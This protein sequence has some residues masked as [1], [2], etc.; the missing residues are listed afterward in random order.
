[1][2]N[3]IATHA[4]R[5]GVSLFGWVCEWVGCDASQPLYHQIYL[6]MGPAIYV[7]EYNDP[8]GALGLGRS[9]HAQR[10][11]AFYIISLFVILYSFLFVLL[12]FFCALGWECLAVPSAHLH[13]EYIVVDIDIS[14]CLCGCADVQTVKRDT[15]IQI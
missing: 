4:I 10:P 7:Y 14:Y 6:R 9:T 8:N 12:I 15:N 3:I 5:C 1:M 13:F 11:E 2:E